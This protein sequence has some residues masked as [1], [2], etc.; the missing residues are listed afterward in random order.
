MDISLV[1]IIKEVTFEGEV[2]NHVLN[3]LNNERN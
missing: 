1:R 3:S 2:V